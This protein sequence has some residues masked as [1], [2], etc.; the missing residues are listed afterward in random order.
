MS[1]QVVLTLR[2]PLEHRLEADAIVPDRFPT[3]GARAIAG[4][5]V[6]YGGRPAALG[7]FFTVTGER[8]ERV[9]VQGDLAWAVGLGRAWWAGSS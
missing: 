3:L 6:W 5:P 8:S 2:A 9:L 4:L 1:D 7:D